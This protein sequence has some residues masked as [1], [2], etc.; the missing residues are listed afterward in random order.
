MTGAAADEGAMLEV[1]LKILLSYMLGSLSGSLVA[2]RFHGG[3]DV[4]EV[5]SGNA[6]ATNA[7][8]NFGWKFAFWVVL[9]D[10]GKGWLPAWLLPG[11]ALPGIGL[12]PQVS[13]EWL[14]VGCGAAAVVG[15]VWPL[16]FG[17]KGGKGAATLV[18]VLLALAPWL[19]VPVL[20]VWVLALI[21]SGY[22][23]LATVVAALS[24]P[25]AWVLAG[26][27]RAN[28]ELFAFTLVMSLFVVYTHRS[29]LRRMHAGT[30]ERIDRVRVFHGRR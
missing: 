28:P 4:R 29:N 30:E 13:R 9:I 15:H 8:R 7:L 16:W 12:D 17:F 10:V 25:A 20:S 22:V 6:G 18:G 3:I 27:A 26:A 23:G 21:L 14:A 11:L 19:L 2:G 1:G 5:G 24:A